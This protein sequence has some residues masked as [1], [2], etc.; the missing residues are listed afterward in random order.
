MMS[1]C[2]IALPDGRSAGLGA[3]MI[4]LMLTALAIL[5]VFA[6]TVWHQ[7]GDRRH[8]PAPTLVDAR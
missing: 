7:H 6:V 2:P 3:P 1:C 8:H 5:T 4:R